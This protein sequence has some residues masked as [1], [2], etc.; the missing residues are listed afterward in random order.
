[1][2]EKNRNQNKNTLDQMNQRRETFDR[3]EHNLPGL[4]QEEKSR[5]Y[6]SYE[7]LGFKGGKRRSEE[8]TSERYR[9]TGG[10]IRPEPTAK[11][12]QTKK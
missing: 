8:D 5:T 6:N 4:D 3:G 7:E 2:E 12:E 11:D 9:D 1:M 10:L